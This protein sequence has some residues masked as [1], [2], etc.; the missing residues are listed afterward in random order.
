MPSNI[1]IKAVLMNRV[2]AEAIAARLSG[3]EPQ[4]FFQEDFFFACDGARLKLRVFAP[5][6]G[7]LIRYERADRAETR[8][9]DYV[10]AHTSD[11]ANLLDILTATLGRVGAVRKI[12]TLYLIGQTRVHLDRVEG[13]GEFMELEVVL[14]PEQSGLEGQR[15]AA[16]LL[17]EFGIRQEQMIAEAY[18]D[19]AATRVH[20]DASVTTMRQQFVYEL[21]DEKTSAPPK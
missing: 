14:R 21:K 6:R 16:E 8:R 11:P 12:R 4:T 15:I 13:L 9:S 19:L 3:S 18:V 1:E 10:I 17:T 5:D 7:E 20:A 2:A